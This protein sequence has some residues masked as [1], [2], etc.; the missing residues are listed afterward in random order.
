MKQN[1]LDS[2]RGGKNNPKNEPADISSCTSSSSL[3]R[4]S[5][6]PGELGFSHGGFNGAGRQ[7]SWGLKII[8]GVGGSIEETSYS[9]IA[10]EQHKDHGLEDRVSIF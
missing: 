8:D 7:G 2:K 6:V 1:R 10:K 9:W 4:A 5:T 3:L